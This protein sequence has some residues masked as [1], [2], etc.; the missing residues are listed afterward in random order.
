MCTSDRI[1]D[2]KR[3]KI[4][5]ANDARHATQA[6]RRNTHRTLATYSRVQSREAPHTRAAHRATTLMRDHQCSD[7]EAH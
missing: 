5:N 6:G 4:T 2:R 1:H 7:E 3:P